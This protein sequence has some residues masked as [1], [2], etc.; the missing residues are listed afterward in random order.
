MQKRKPLGPGQQD[1]ALSYRAYNYVSAVPDYPVGSVVHMRHKTPTETTRDLLAPMLKVGGEGKGPPKETLSQDL[2][3][4]LWAWFND[5]CKT[6]SFVPLHRKGNYISAKDKNKKIRD[7]NPPDILPS[8]D[9]IAY[10]YRCSFNFNEKQLL[11]TGKQGRGALSTRQVLHD[12]DEYFIEALATWHRNRWFEVIE[13]GGELLGPSESVHLRVS[14]LNGYKAAPL[15]NAM[16]EDHS[17]SMHSEEDSAQFLDEL[18]KHC[19]IEAL[20]QSYVDEMQGSSAND[21]S[22]EEVLPFYPEIQQQRSSNQAKLRRRHYCRLERPGI[23]ALTSYLKSLKKPYVGRPDLPYPDLMKEELD[24][25]KACLSGMPLPSYLEDERQIERE[26]YNARHTPCNVTVLIKKPSLSLIGYEAGY[27]SHEYNKQLKAMSLAGY[28]SNSD[29]LF[30]KLN[31]LSMTVDRTEVQALIDKYPISHSTRW[32]FK[33]VPYVVKF[34]NLLDSLHKKVKTPQDGTSEALS[35]HTEGVFSKVIDKYGNML[36]YATSYA[37]GHMLYQQIQSEVEEFRVSVTAATMT[38]SII[39]RHFTREGLPDTK[40]VDN[41][42]LFRSRTKS[43]TKQIYIEPSDAGS[44]NN[45]VILT[46]DNEGTLAANAAVIKEVIPDLDL[47][48]KVLDRTKTACPSC[49]KTG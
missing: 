46:F 18:T 1:R 45:S 49:G 35:V 10:R 25:E 37:D 33:N 13:R 24:Y 34:L 4:K 22:V 6:F 38:D 29:I 19:Q 41:L 23:E 20:K 36:D 39:E 9:H 2:N 27:H 47:Y 15:D 28:E 48:N 8:T 14:S 5:N 30:S 12:S 16:E 43:F 42:D 40:W 26:M 3:P 11:Y 44:L 21:S 7:L 31:V 17:V 32:K